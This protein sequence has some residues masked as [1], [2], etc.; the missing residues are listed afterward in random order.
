M[1]VTKD[2]IKRIHVHL[3]KDVINE[4][5]AK[6]AFVYSF[7]SDPERTST[8]HL[9]FEEANQALIS[10]GA[11]PFKRPFVRLDNWQKFD[12]KK[13]SHMNIL[14]LLKQMDW[15]YKSDVSNRY[16][17][18]MVRFGNWLQT[19]APIK[20]PLNEMNANEVSIT[21]VVLEKMVD[22]YNQKQILA[23]QNG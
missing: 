12:Y 17:A 6:K 3:H 8:K 23:T 20:K 18:D 10:L 1:Q 16:F 15:Q 13:K 22:Q 7:T 9:T 14:S 2:Q 21:I 11:K 19:K 5:E 4:P